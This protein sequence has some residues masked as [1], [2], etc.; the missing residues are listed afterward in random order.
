MIGQTAS[1]GDAFRRFEPGGWGVVFV[2]GIVPSGRRGIDRMV[3]KAR[4][5]TRGPDR[6]PRIYSALVIRCWRHAYPALT[7]RAPHVCPGKRQDASLPWNDELGCRP[8]P[9]RVPRA[10][11]KM[12]AI[13]AGGCD[14]GGTVISGALSRSVAARRIE[15]R[16][17]SGRATTMKAGPR[18]ERSAVTCR[19]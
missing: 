13:E 15:R 1:S 17:P 11:H 9:H 8:V 16:R 5:F 10:H 7:P 19:R 18:A 2:Q 14:G 6:A 4:P 12:W 3:P